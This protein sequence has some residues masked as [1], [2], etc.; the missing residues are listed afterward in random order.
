MSDEPVKAEFKVV[1]GGLPKAESNPTSVFNDL[2]S[3]R[4]E[5]KLTVRRKSVLVNVTVDKPPSD[6]YFRAHPDWA[7]DDAT[8]IKT[9][10]GDFLFVLPAMRGHPKLSPRLRR[11]TLAAII[12]WPADEM[13]IW[14]VP[15][16]GDRDFSVWKTARRAYDLSKEPGRKW[17]GPTR[18]ATTPWKRLRKSITTRNGRRRPLRNY[19]RSG[20]TAR[21]S[22]TRTTPMSADCAASSISWLG[23]FAS[24]WHV[25][26]EYRQD[27]NHCPVPVS[28]FAYE[29][30]TGT[31][32]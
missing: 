23:Q 26:F 7:L 29:E 2:A 21:S 22:T 11:V 10:G 28:M 20:L 15:I 14:P 32:L 16:L 18:S 30:H 19:S 9:D 1:E 6:T 24:V 5:Q 12:T 31:E 17:S 25:D 4:K 13:M 8:V 3:L 27:A